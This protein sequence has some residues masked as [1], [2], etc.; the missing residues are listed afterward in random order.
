MKQFRSSGVLRSFSSLPCR[1]EKCRF[2]NIL[3]NV[4]APKDEAGDGED[5]SQLGAAYRSLGTAARKL[6]IVLPPVDMLAPD[7]PAEPLPFFPLPASMQQTHRR[8]WESTEKQYNNYV[9][10]NVTPFLSKIS[11]CTHQIVLVDVLGI[12]RSL[13]ANEFNRTRKSICEVLRLL[14]YRDQGGWPWLGPLQTPAKW[15]LSQF[16]A[17]IQRVTFVCTKADQAAAG[18]RNNLV[19]LLKRLVEQAAA[20]IAFQLSASAG[21]ITYHS[22]ASHRSTSDCTTEFDGQRLFT[23]CGRLNNCEY[24]SDQKV[25]PGEVPEEW[26]TTRTWKGYRF[27]DFAPRPLPAVNGTPLDHINLDRILYE[28]IA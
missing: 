8:L 17:G 4:P 21:R 28:L 18:S 16:Q 23:L 6:G 25:F 11:N 15:V 24:D 3:A 1:E 26:P 27:V 19:G 20:D 5:A 14:H 2:E 10:Q 13:D 7:A 22:T 12:L 9:V